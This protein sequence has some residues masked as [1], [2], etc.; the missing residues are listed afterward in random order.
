ML[1]VRRGGRLRVAVRCLRRLPVR[2]GLLTVR[3]GLRLP[4]VPVHTGLWFVRSTEALLW[5]RL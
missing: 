3:A 5:R 2:T 4:R 1:A